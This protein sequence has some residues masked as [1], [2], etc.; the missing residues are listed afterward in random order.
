MMLNVLCDSFI[1]AYTFALIAGY[2]CCRRKTS[3]FSFFNINYLVVSN[4]LLT[5]THTHIKGLTNP[6]FVFCSAR[7]SCA[8]APCGE[9]SPSPP[10]SSF[11]VAVLGRLSLPIASLC[12]HRRVRLDRKRSYSPSIII[13]KKQSLCKKIKTV[14]ISVSTRLPASL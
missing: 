13:T 2:E 11:R 3:F 8:D 12:R 10:P 7:V 5:H 9:D 14:R 6:Y 4:N 1:F